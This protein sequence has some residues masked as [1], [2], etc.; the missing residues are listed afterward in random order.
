[1]WYIICCLSLMANIISRIPVAVL[2]LHLWYIICMVNHSCHA[3][4]NK[5]F[6]RTFYI[7]QYFAN[8]SHHTICYY[9][10]TYTIRGI[11]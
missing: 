5:P 9:D 3:I 6:K 8:D 4:R 11:L 1:M 7:T 10:V 2:H